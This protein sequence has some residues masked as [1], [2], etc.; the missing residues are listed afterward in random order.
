V[1]QIEIILATQSWKFLGIMDKLYIVE[2]LFFKSDKSEKSN[3]PMFSVLTNK[4]VMIK[5]SGNWFHFMGA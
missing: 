2:A 1:K 5:H 3:F 4:E